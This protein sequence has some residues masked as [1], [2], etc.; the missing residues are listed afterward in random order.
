MEAQLEL[1]EG[2]F[3]NMSA[4][5]SSSFDATVSGQR[6]FWLEKLFTSQKP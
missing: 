5:K 1:V 3:T 6:L 4:E 2:S